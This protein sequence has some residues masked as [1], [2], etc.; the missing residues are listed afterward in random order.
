M[1]N[2]YQE[3]EVFEIGHA[4][5]IVLGGKGTQILDSQSDPQPSNVG[6]IDESDE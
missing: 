4:R 5:D 6:D 1:T 3:P 2:N